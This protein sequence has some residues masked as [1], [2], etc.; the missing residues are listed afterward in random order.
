MIPDSVELK[1]TIRALSL[2]QFDH[3]RERVTEVPPLCI[4][5]VSS[6]FSKVITSGSNAIQKKKRQMML[7]FCKLFLFF[8]IKTSA[9]FRS[10]HIRLLQPPPSLLSPVPSLWSDRCSCACAACFPLLPVF[11]SVAAALL[12]MPAEPAPVSGSVAVS[13]PLL[14]MRLLSLFLDAFA[15]PCLHCLV[16]LCTAA[17]LP[18]LLNQ[19]FVNEGKDALVLI[20]AKGE[21][22]CCLHFKKM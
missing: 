18:A 7:M 10:T 2:R 6:T 19:K 3:L 1:G 4:F 17:P 5:C 21:T 12:A 22:A 16:P 8:L 9:F 13:L 11:A 15:H 14:P 20:R